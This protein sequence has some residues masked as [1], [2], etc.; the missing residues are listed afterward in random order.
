MKENKVLENTFLRI[1]IGYNSAKFLLVSK[2]REDSSSLSLRTADVF[3]VVPSLPPKV[4]F[5]RERS[6]ERKYVCG[7]QA[8]VRFDR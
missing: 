7:S 5:R 4:N 6:D 2:I 1:L 3:P 8:R